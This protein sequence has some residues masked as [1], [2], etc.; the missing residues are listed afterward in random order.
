MK[1]KAYE[2]T[3][4]RCV[5]VKVNERRREYKECKKQINGIENE[6]KRR[7]DEEFGRNLSENKNLFL[8]K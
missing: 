2:R 4:L 6:S 7:V 1:R 3:F 8:R 5:L